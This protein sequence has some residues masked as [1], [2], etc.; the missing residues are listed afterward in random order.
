MGKVTINREAVSLATI[1]SDALDT[2][3]TEAE[4]KN[5]ALEFNGR[6]KYLVVNADPVRL[7][8]IAWN[9]LNNAV[10]FT[11]AG[12]KITISLAQDGSNA[13]LS[14]EDTG[15]G[16]AP[17]FLPH[18]FEIFRQADASSSRKQ[19][20][21][22]IGLAL[23]KQLAELHGGSVNAESA[24]VGK[25]ARFIVYL[26]L[27]PPTRLNRVHKKGN[28]GILNKKSI[29]VVDDSRETSEMLGKLLQ[30]EGAFVRTASSGLEALSLAETC[31]FD[32]VITDISMP[33]MDGYQFL[34]ALR[35]LPHMNAIP[36]LALT[37]FGRHSDIDRARREG[38]ADHFTKPLNIDELL[39]TVRRLTHA[40][41]H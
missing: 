34:R 26:P 20:G 29:L 1:V 17:E 27:Q 23:V 22:G 8:Q 36:A 10:K 33:E 25:G 18:V 30:M 24:G 5:I 31:D 41:S 14:V 2:V 35:S 38:F 11:S 12:G 15:Q 3:R 39:I 37:G 13:F 32:L 21:L 16:I 4:E 28:T 7:G 9:L 6:N 19:G 40:E